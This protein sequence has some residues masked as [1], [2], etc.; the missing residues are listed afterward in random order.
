MGM[1][2]PTHIFV[3]DF[4]TLV[5][6]VDV[7]EINLVVED[8]KD[9][10]VEDLDDK[11]LNIIKFADHDEATYSFNQFKNLKIS[12]KAPRILVHVL[13]KQASAKVYSI[14]WKEDGNN[15]K[16]SGDEKLGFCRYIEFP[17]QLVD[18]KTLN[19]KCM[20][21]GGKKKIT[22]NVKI[23]RV[24]KAYNARLSSIKVRCVE[25]VLADGSYEV[26]IP[27]NAEHIEKVEVNCED[28]K[29][30]YVVKTYL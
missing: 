30:K 21:A 29:C 23:F 2:L 26:T 4:E 3:A 10:I 22:K 19:I 13:V 16:P 9:S 18:T 7:Y 6:E 28:A 5:N 20:S 17:N 14:A 11:N 15:I 1:W 8:V 25:A 24:D 12:N 27:K